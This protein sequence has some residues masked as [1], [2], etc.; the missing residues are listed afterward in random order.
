MRKIC[1]LTCAREFGLK[2]WIPAS[3]GTTDWEF[4]HE[5]RFKSQPDFFTFLFLHLFRDNKGLTVIPCEIC[6]CIRIVDKFL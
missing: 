6:V 3:A 4:R 1:C 5:N 2:Q